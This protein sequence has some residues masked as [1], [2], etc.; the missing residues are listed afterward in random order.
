[1]PTR[2][3]TPCREPGCAELLDRPGRC[4]AHARKYDRAVK[5]RQPWRSYGGPEW[6]RAR[7]TK[8]ERYPICQRDGC[9]APSV[10]VH[11]LVS[12]R[13]LWEEHGEIP[14]WAHGDENTEALCKHH[15]SIET[16]KE[17]RSRTARARRPGEG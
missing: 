13:D 14:S 3:R 4:A 9:T 17:I 1:M 16:Q 10:D 12:L 11:H 2:P 8:L 7:R 6:K 5:T 15:H